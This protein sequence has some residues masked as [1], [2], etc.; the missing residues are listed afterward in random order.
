[1][2]KKR[3]FIAMNVPRGL[4]NAAETRMKPFFDE[5]IVR[6]SKREGWH[7]ALVFYG[8]LNETGLN[9]L[10]DVLDETVLL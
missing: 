4:K 3:I 8:C 7:I 10:K 6:V 9:A 5:K 1:M 2:N